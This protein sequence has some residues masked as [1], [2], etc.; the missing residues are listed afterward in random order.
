MKIYKA[1]LCKYNIDNFGKNLDVSNY[2]SLLEIYVTFNK[3]HYKE[4][5]TG[6]TFF[7][8]N[9][10]KGISLNDSNYRQY[11]VGIKDIT[12][13]NKKDRN[14][15]IQLREYINRHKKMIELENYFLNVILE[16]NN[17]LKRFYDIK[18]RSN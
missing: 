9:D 1:K 11:S 16:V 10:F 4:L 12:L 14:D 7:D 2:I 6:M 17:S 5:M 15:S 3:N 13:L 8:I 18:K